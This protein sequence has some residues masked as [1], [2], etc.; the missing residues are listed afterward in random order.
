M[1]CSNLK[2]V[3]WIQISIFAFLLIQVVH[4]NE[5]KANSAEQDV[6]RIE[7]T[8][9]EL[10]G[11]LAPA[12][13]KILIDELQVLNSN[14]MP[15]ET[16]DLRK[17]IVKMRDILD[18]FSESYR[19]KKSSDLWKIVRKDLD[20]G[21]EEFGAFKDLFDSQGLEILPDDTEPNS[22]NESKY[23]KE[24]DIT[25]ADKEQVNKLRKALL[26]WKDSFLEFK[27]KDKI[28]TF[29]SS[30][31]KPDGK[32]NNWSD[33]SKFYW[34]GLDF[35]PRS[36]FSGFENICA[37]LNGQARLTL[38]DLEETLKI[39]TPY[40]IKQEI[41]FH[42]FRKRMRTIVKTKNIFEQFSNSQSTC[43][44]SNID[45]LEPYVS[46]FGEIEDLI[47]GRKIAEEAKKRKLGEKKK[48]DILNLWRT[49]KAKVGSNEFESMLIQILH[50]TEIE[51]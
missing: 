25:Y 40:K 20:S 9:S 31:E 10:A 39:D 45:S 21:H 15:H 19:T 17:T 36:N 37:L 46:Q 7:S 14:T 26:K 38:I 22:A 24:S 8:Y 51:N 23:V 5:V 32:R 4:F 42:D 47:V 2:K 1:N 48:K 12:Q 35:A 18:I 11:Q 27:N 33:L 6:F 41:I 29:L 16:K 49:L 13:M 3:N 28:M 34:G 50:E 44:T 43:N 30:P